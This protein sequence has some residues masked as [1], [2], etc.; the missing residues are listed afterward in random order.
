MGTRTSTVAFIDVGNIGRSTFRGREDLHALRSTR[1]QF[2]DPIVL[3]HGGQ[4][5]VQRAVAHNRVQ[6]VKCARGGLSD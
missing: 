5:V 2:A 1:E 6:R 3:Q 4:D